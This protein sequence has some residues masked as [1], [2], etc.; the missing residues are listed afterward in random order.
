MGNWNIIL[1]TRKEHELVEEVNRY[2]WMLLTSQAII[3]ALTLDLDDGWKIFYF[4][5]EPTKV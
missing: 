5:V 4:G 1:L 3:L 2:L